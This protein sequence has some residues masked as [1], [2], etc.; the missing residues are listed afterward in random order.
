MPKNSF[1]TCV[2]IVYKIVFGV[3]E[4]FIQIV[5][6]VFVPQKLW[7][8]TEFMPAKFAYFTHNFPQNFRGFYNSYWIVFAPF[9]HNLLLRLL[10]KIINRNL[11]FG[12]NK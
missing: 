9:P 11:T 12:I 7:Q 4:E 6:K 1:K 3:G 5:Q 10:N 2:Q 8:T